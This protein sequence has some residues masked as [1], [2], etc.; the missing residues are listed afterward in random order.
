MPSWKA[1]NQ[2]Q[3]AG[4][5]RRSTFH[6]SDQPRPRLCV[7]APSSQIRHARLRLRESPSVTPRASEYEAPATFAVVSRVPPKRCVECD[8]VAGGLVEP[9]GVT[10]QLWAFTSTG[11]HPNPLPRGEGEEAQ[12]KNPGPLGPRVPKSRRYLLS[13]QRQYHR[14][15]VLNGRVRNGIGC[16]HVPK[17]TDKG[18]RRLSTA[19]PEGIGIG[20]CCLGSCQLSS[21]GCQL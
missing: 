7:T 18:A 9:A 12:E 11:P 5:A 16:F 1:Q 6:G 3:P 4:H 19:C 15:H 2:Q 13:R 10:R 8:Q 21:D 17:V 14:R 20:V